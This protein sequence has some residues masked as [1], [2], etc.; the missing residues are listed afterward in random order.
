MWRVQGQAPEENRSE[1][2]DEREDREHDVVGEERTL[3]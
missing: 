1:K 3:T 2:D